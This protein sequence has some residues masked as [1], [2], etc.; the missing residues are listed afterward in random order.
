MSAGATTGATSAAA[1]SGDER[2]PAPNA[3][4]PDAY[5]KLPPTLPIRGLAPPLKGG[6]VTT[7]QYSFN[8]PPA[9]R[10]SNAYWQEI[11]KRVGTKIE[12]T[13]VPYGSY[14]EKL[15]PVF[16]GGAIPDLVLIDARPAP[17]LNR[18]MQQGAF[19]DLTPYVT[20][21]A[22]KEF[23][24]LARF[25]AQLWK[26][27]AIRGKLYGVPRP[28]AFAANPMIFRQDWAEKLGVRDVR[29]K[30]DL[31][32]VLVGMT[33]MDPDGNGTADTFGL[34]SQSG[35]A[36]YLAFFQQMWRTPNEWRVNPDGTL[37][38]A[39]ELDES[40]AA[41]SFMRELWAAGGYHPDAANMTV[42][43]CKDNFAAGKIGAFNDSF[44]TL[45]G[46]K[47]PASK[48]GPLAVTP[49]ANVTGLVPPGWDGGKAVTFAS[50]GVNAMTGIPSRIKD[51]A[52]I[53]ELLRVL[54]YFAAPF[55]SEERIF[56]D[57]GIEGTHFEYKNGTP[58]TNDA[59]KAQQGD[60][61]NLMLGPYVLYSGVP[62]AAAATQKV[63]IDTIALGV[64]NPCISAYSPTFAMK[65]G[66]LNQLVN[67]RVIAIVTGRDPLTAWDTFVKDWRSRGG[68]QMRR[69]YQDF[70]KQ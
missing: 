55:G 58:T 16:A 20:G 59:F 13:F 67:D 60:F 52:R 39:Y 35:T 30:D 18:I 27:A 40:R 14:A 29:N 28:R 10:E 5:T 64:D 21:D 44:L 19:N 66:E 25:P 57:Y 51:P 8:P 26:N 3:N 38:H 23:P 41:V 2:I 42:A 70:L 7:F 62:G 15:G 24:N 11:E 69:E 63:L 47:D 37:T 54:D 34:T 32:K 56:L 33:K 1:G 43:Q 6:T 9:A 4:V 65:A 22:L 68:D 61:Q 36:L 31:L 48:G 46:Y 50:N 12:P 53:K 45:P 49:T 17:D